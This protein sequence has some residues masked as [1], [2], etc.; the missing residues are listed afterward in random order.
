MFKCFT[1]EKEAPLQL[2]NIMSLYVLWREL[3]CMWYVG[4]FWGLVVCLLVG[5]FFRGSWNAV[6]YFIYLLGTLN[7][8][9]GFL[10]LHCVANQ[11]AFRRGKAERRRRPLH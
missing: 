2:V 6:F 11:D 9:I 3:S 7:G 4:L 5:R 8:L 10:P 1:S